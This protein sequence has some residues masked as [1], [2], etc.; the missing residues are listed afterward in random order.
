MGG[1]CSSHLLSALCPAR[2]ALLVADLRQRIADPVCRCRP[3][4]PSCPLTFL[5]CIPS[6]PCLLSL[7]THTPYPNVVK[8]V[9][10]CSNLFRTQAQLRHPPTSAGEAMALVLASGLTSRQSVAASSVP[11]SSV[12]VEAAVGVQSSCLACLHA[13]MLHGFSTAT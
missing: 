2:A 12:Q 1:A 3:S 8:V 6:C 13:C 9:V 11:P 10:S 7:L 5:R 4:D